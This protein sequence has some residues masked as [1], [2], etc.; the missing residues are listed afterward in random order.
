MINHRHVLAVSVLALVA[1]S[2][3]AKRPATATTAAPAPTGGSGTTMSRPAEGT[4]PAAV[5]IQPSGSRTSPTATASARPVPSEYVD[6]ADLKDVHFEFDKSDIRT[7][8]TTV[9]D[10]NARWL[11]SNAGHLVLIEGH[12]DERGTNE[13][14]VALGDRRA[15]S[16]RNYLVA[17]GIAADR[18]TVVSYGEERPACS[19][20]SEGCWQ[21]NRRAHFRVKPQ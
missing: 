5:S 7:E 18:I 13:Y 14:N 19:D 12:C 11:K 17:Q 21:K 6:H 8:D 10:A 1:F 20:K 15:R 9:L 16:T 3:C 4:R 2:G